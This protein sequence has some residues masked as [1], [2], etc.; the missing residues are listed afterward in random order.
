MDVVGVSPSLPFSRSLPSSLSFLL[1]LFAL[2]DDKIGLK[3][4]SKSFE[5]S[6]AASGQ[7]GA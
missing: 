1:A 7:S 6:Q 3:K 5:T 2:K 4:N